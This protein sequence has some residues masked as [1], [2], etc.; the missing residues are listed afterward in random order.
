[1][2]AAT[3]APMPE[4]SMPSPNMR[5]TP[6]STTIRASP[7]NCRPCIRATNSCSA[8]ASWTSW[9]RAWPRWRKW[10][11]TPISA[12]ASTPRR[13]T[14]SICR[15]TSLKPSP[16]MPT[17][18]AGTV[19]AWSSRPMPGSP[20]RC[21]NGSAR[22]LKNLTGVSP[23]VSSRAPTGTWRSSTPRF[24]ACRPI[25]CSPARPPPTSPI[26][27]APVSCSTI[28]TGS[29]RNLPP[30]TPTPPVP[31]WKWPAM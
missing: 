2:H 5:Q 21:W 1:M 27:P 19:S 4:R 23:S 11:A 14:G 6:M 30:T 22:W 8:G 28:S 12:S 24:S 16:A 25:R 20:C 13:P 29:T 9:C 10:R 3:F 7:S 31:F 26:S 18:P 15:S 17:S